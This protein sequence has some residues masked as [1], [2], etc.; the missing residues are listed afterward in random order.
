MDYLAQ[1]KTFLDRAEATNSAD[2]RTA[3]LQMAAKMLS[4]AHDQLSKVI[5]RQEQ[6]NSN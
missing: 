2:E 1:G 3:H 6:S 4:K 5:D